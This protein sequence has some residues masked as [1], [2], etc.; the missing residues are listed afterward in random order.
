MAAVMT[1]ALADFAS[2]FANDE[3]PT[4]VLCV[5][6]AVRTDRQRC[7]GC[8]DGEIQE[9]AL[10]ERAI[11]VDGIDVPV[12]T[13]GVNNTPGVDRGGVDAPF[14]AVGVRVGNARD[15]SVRS[16]AAAI[17]FRIPESPSD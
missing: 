4:I 6:Q 5:D 12:F 13:V 3:Q 15:G 2:V 9:E 10:V 17:G 16:T 7:I 1:T 14:E 8:A 11:R